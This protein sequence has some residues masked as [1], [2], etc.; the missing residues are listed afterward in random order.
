M[1]S[2]QAGQRPREGHD[3]PDLQQ[4]CDELQGQVVSLQQQQ[5]T[6]KETKAD[7]ELKLDGADN[8]EHEWK[9]PGL[10]FQFEIAHK[11]IGFLRTG[12]QAFEDD[13]IKKGIEFV[14]KG[15]KELKD[16][17][18][19]LKIAD[20][21]GGGW[22]TV[23]AYKAIPVADD[24]DDDRKLKKA[25]KVAKDR[26]AMRTADKKTRQTCNR[27]RFGSHPYRDQY[28]GVPYSGELP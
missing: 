14:H 22:D 25:E 12:L 26:L 4:W 16:R 3:G 19:M 13:K 28:M 1:I 27:T 23:N 11:S 7:L 9:K 18:K 10:K 2:G 5:L 24:S 8:T 17:I 15:I 21:S 6:A 20:S